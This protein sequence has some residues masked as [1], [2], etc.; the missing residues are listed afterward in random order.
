MSQ[1]DD[2]SR[3][4]VDSQVLLLAQSGDMKAAD[5]LPSHFGGI[6]TLC[7]HKN[8]GGLMWT[9]TKRILRSYGLENHYDILQDV[10]SEA[11]C[12]ILRP[13]IQ[14]YNPEKCSPVQYISGIVR[15]AAK[16]IV[17][18][19]NN[20]VNH[21]E[22]HE[23]TKNSNDGSE[24]YE[25]FSCCEAEEPIAQL[26]HE[27]NSIKLRTTLD[28]T[29]ACATPDIREVIQRRYYNNEAMTKIA[30]LKGVERTALTHQIRRFMNRHRSVF[31]DIYMA[32]YN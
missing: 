16:K 30:L 20:K 11:Y 14:N 2:K 9:L 32:Y 7:G 31:E 29:L 27:E 18:M 24:Y 23:D 28:N 15:N 10:I 17:R 21:N 13:D 8:N 22:C 12:Q 4:E 1:K 3:S 19:I 26:I 25:C 5:L 6:E